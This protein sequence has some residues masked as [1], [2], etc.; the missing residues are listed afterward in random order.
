MKLIVIVFF[1][2]LAVGCQTPQTTPRP[3][4]YSGGDGSSREQAVVISDMDCREAGT[5]AEMLWLTRNYPGYREASQ[6]ALNT[7]SRKYDVVEF[8][9]AEGQSK[10]VYFDTTE[11]TDR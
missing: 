11:C 2:L 7:A 5:L 8:A 3:I 10:K 4:A 9:T 1:A 6:T